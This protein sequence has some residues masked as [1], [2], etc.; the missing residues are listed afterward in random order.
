MLM[1]W[2]LPGESHDK[3]LSG[4]HVLMN[5]T[6]RELHECHCFALLQLGYARPGMPILCGRCNAAVLPRFPLEPNIWMLKAKDFPK[7]INGR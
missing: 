6:S 3:H 1:R 4:Q 2:P 7:S 5:V